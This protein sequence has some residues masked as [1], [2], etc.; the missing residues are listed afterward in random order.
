M[1]YGNA[2]LYFDPEGYSISGPRLMGR[3]AAGHGF[4]NGMFRHARVDRFMAFTDQTTAF[5]AFKSMALDAGVKTPVQEISKVDMGR[6]SEVGCVF[7][8]GPGLG[9][10]A[11]E[12]E[13]FGSRAWSLCGITH[14]TL[15]GR[16]MDG[17][18]GLLTEPLHS[19]DAVICTSQIGRAHV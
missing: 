4:L 6:L 15:S 5:S 3:N 9:V 10:Q 8:P 18:A 7:Y 1:T 17:I 14:T 16:A 13:L 19:W 2:A 11:W 12:R